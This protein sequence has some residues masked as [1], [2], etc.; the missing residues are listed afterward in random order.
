MIMYLLK[1]FFVAKT[2]LRDLSET[3]KNNPKKAFL[4][5]FRRGCMRVK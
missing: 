1:I 5:E 4:R 2:W 3:L